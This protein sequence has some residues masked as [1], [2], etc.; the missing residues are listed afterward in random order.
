MDIINKRGFTSLFI[1]VG[2]TVVVL[3]YLI[4]SSFPTINTVKESKQ[5]ENSM[6]LNLKNRIG[7]ERIYSRLYENISYNEY[8][9]YMDIDKKYRVEELVIEHEV[10]ELDVWSSS[11]T[12]FDIDINNKT[13]IDVDVTFTEYEDLEPGQWGYY[14]V[15]IK[16][17]GAILVDDDFTESTIAS[18]NDRDVYNET[19]GTFNYGEYHIELTPINGYIDAVVRYK[20][21]MYREI[22]LIENNNIVRKIVLEKDESG[23]DVAKNK[24]YLVNTEE[25]IV[26]DI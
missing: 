5:L 22:N 17:S 13:W 14:N 3:A 15:Y 21:Q 9:E 4:A 26:S 25:D 11:K 20:E 10:R 7:L 18:I 8:V 23:G 2:I 1:I 19:T 16:Y 12:M 6:E 24:I